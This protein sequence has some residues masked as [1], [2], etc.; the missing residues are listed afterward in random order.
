M[1]RAGKQQT[2]F[3]LLGY[4]HSP[5]FLVYC[6]LLASCVRLNCFVRWSQCIKKGI[7]APCYGWGHLFPCELE[8][9]WRCHWALNEASRGLL[10]GWTSGGGVVRRWLL[11]RGGLHNAA[12]PGSLLPR[13]D[14]MGLDGAADGSSDAWLGWSL[15]PFPLS[16][17][18][19]CP[20]NAVIFWWL[21]STEEEISQSMASITGFSPAPLPG[22]SGMTFGAT[23]ASCQPPCS[24]RCT[25]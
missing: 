14:L 15:S 3:D 22:S 25:L 16:L 17:P 19:P 7:Q 18:S 5:H 9:V 10:L 20:S 6:S 8:L 4:Q 23:M 13:F 1:S 2:S 11:F 12:R 21:V 24:T